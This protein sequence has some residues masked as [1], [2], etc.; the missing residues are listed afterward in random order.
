MTQITPDE[1]YSLYWEIVMS[2]TYRNGLLR[3]IQVDALIQLLQLCGC[4]AFI[5]S[6][7]QE[8]MALIVQRLEQFAQA[9]MGKKDR[10]ILK[11]RIECIRAE[12]DNLFR[13]SRPLAV[14]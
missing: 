2:K 6:R 3:K 8:E 1:I 5:A 7:S 9:G 10:G 13:R 4:E 14:N 12:L 11:D